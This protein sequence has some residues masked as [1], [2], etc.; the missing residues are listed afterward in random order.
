MKK[1]KELFLIEP[2]NKADA[3]TLA[4]IFSSSVFNEL[5]KK[6]SSSLL[7]S[8][9][10]ELNIEQSSFS[11]L[12]DL[13]DSAYKYLQVV[14]RN[15]YLYKNTITNKLLLGKHSL[16]TS[17]MLTE[18]RVSS[19]KAD[20]LI[21]NGTSH[22]YEVKTELDSLERLEQQVENYSKF[23]EHVHVVTSKGHLDKILN[24]MPTNI[25]V[26]ELTTKNTLKTIRKSESNMERLSSSVIFESLRQSEYCKIIKKH[27]GSLPEVSNALMFKECRNLFDKLPHNECN[28]LVVDTLKQRNATDYQRAFV[29]SVPESLKAMA[30]STHFSKT[31]INNLSYSLSKGII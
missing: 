16:N 31:Q 27:F 24:N 10:K 20:V 30:V 18:F 11:K 25:G 7:N 22:I 29:E 13:F 19:S 26:I 6:G 3:S 12:S 14:Y 9:I 1:N 23:A 28:K 8:I 21:L 5:A 2:S 17:K 15:E 4:R